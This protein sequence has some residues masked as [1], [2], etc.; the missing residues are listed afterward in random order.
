MQAV[1]AE[2]SGCPEKFYCYLEREEFKTRC[3]DSFYSQNLLLD[4]RDRVCLRASLPAM[5]SSI[6]K[7]CDFCGLARQNQVSVLDP[8]VA[9]RPIHLQLVPDRQHF[10]DRGY[11]DDL[12]LAK[13][14]R[15]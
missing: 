7:A 14:C 2:F 15:F 6:L 13:F 11:G 1:A 5:S 4:R 12:Q 8:D 3:L 10:F 9:H